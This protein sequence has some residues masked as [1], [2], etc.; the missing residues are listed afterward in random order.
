MWDLVLNNLFKDL[1]PH[2]VTFCELGPRHIGLENTRQRER[3]V[4]TGL[5]AHAAGG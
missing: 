1:Y 5:S 3:A 2:T 4:P